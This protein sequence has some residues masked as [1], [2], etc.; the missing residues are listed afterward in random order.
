MMM[1]CTRRSGE[2]LV[3]PLRIVVIAPVYLSVL[4]RKIAPNTI[5]NTETVMP[6][7]CNTEAITRLADISQNIRAI[8]TVRAKATGMAFLA[9][10]LRPTSKI[11]AT[12][13]GEKA[14]NASNVSFMEYFLVLELSINRDELTRTE[15]RVRLT[16]KSSVVDF[17]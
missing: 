1:A 2:M 4:S 8:A 9:G 6:K 11:A 3:K 5:H 15:C 13:M 7:P 16:S 12:I 10:Q 14:T 17:L